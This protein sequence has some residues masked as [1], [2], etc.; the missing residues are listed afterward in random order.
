MAIPAAPDG[1]WKPA[2]RDVTNGNAKRAGL[3][4]FCCWLG[5]DGDDGDDEEALRRRRRRKTA[6]FMAWA[7]NV[8]L[9]YSI[10]PF[11]LRTAYTQCTA[12]ESARVVKHGPGGLDAG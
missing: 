1:R 8:A 4:G 5:G 10:I 3:G 12:R 11:I 9:G 2:M 6:C 7:E